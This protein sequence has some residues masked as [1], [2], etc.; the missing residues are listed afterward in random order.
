MPAR[1]KSEVRIDRRLRKVSKSLIEI[2]F[3]GVSSSGWFATYTDSVTVSVVFLFA[4]M[5]C[6]RLQPEVWSIL[7]K[8]LAETPLFRPA[9]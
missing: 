4:F 1:Q 9:F 5:N 7:D 8:A 2:N 6:L 3:S